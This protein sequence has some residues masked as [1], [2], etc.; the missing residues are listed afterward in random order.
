MAECWSHPKR[1][2]SQHGRFAWNVDQQ[3]LSGHGQSVQEQLFQ[4]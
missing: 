1:Y 2:T 3:V 4:N